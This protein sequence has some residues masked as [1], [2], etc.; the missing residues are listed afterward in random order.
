MA[1]AWSEGEKS[2]K[3]PSIAWI[4]AVG[5]WPDTRHRCQVGQKHV[6]EAG[7]R[8]IGCYCADSRA[9]RSTSVPAPWGWAAQTIPEQLSSHTKE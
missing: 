4:N 9:Y 3:E 8:A 7:A 6:I 1:T 2:V 5:G